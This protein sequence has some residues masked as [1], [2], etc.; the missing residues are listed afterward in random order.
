M[1]KYLVFIILV[2]TIISANAQNT[3]INSVEKF[4]LLKVGLVTPGLAY[5]Q[6]LN[7]NCSFEIG[8]HANPYF[9]SALSDNI[10]FAYALNIEGRR[11]FKKNS[12]A[13]GLYMAASLENVLY[14]KIR[15]L[16]LDTYDNRLRPGYF[17]GLKIGYQKVYDGGFF[18]NF[19]LGY[20]I[21]GIY[22]EFSELSP[23]F[24]IGIG[25]I[26]GQKRLKNRKAQLE[27]LETVEAQN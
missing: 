24:R 11:Y 18:M 25:F 21:N 16:K 27:K 13:N 23:T 9:I 3:D 15:N 6:A 5:E 8:F 17:A 4:R 12:F 20:G 26:I 1:R 14:P 22:N 10:Q 7:K 19:A 2:A